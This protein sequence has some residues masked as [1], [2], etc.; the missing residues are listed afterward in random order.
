MENLTKAQHQQP[1]NPL[2]SNWEWPGQCGLASYYQRILACQGV[3]TLSKTLNLKDILRVGCIS[4]LHVK[5]NKAHGFVERHF[6]T[7]LM[8]EPCPR[9][10][11]TH[12]LT[13]AWFVQFNLVACLQSILQPRQHIRKASLLRYSRV[14]ESQ[15]GVL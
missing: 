8:A 3:S 4:V 10:Q 13:L 1:E 9:G 14:I 11:I 2:I 6:G 15:C 7:L 12:T 5:R